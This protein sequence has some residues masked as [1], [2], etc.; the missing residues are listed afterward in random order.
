MSD[1][2]SPAPDREAT[3]LSVEHAQQVLAPALGQKAA[4][5]L[6]TL[7]RELRLVL[8]IGVIMIGIIEIGRASCRERVYVLV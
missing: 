3:A 4:L 1:T 2:R 7:V 5:G 8:L 6:W